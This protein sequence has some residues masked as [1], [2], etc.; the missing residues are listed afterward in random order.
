MCGPKEQQ[1]GLRK[2]MLGAM[3]LACRLAGLSALKENYDAIVAT[4]PLGSVG[5]A[6]KRTD[7]GE[8]L[9]EL[10]RHAL[11]RLDAQRQPGE[12]YSDVILHMAQIEASRPDSRCRHSC[13][14]GVR[15]ATVGA[16]PLSGVAES[17]LTPANDTKGPGDDL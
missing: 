3:L 15:H 14:R 7:N 10:E 17:T 11:D 2:Q 16:P 12:G 1:I 4:L 8:V 9:I 6:A 5:Y 13:R